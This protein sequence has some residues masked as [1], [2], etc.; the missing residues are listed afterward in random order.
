[1]EKKKM[2]DRRYKLS[3]E[4][5]KVLIRLRLEQYYSQREI[6]EKLGISE[7]HVSRLC[8]KHIPDH[9]LKIAEDRNLLE[10]KS[11]QGKSQ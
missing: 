8:K 1:M 4:D 5:I 10:W 2:I 7:S 6:S 9:V 3:P 11:R